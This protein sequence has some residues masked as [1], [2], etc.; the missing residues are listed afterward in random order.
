[1]NSIFVVAVTFI[2]DYISKCMILNHV[3]YGKKITVTSFFNVVH[4][5]NLG[6]SFSLFSNQFAYG[7]YMLAG[8]QFCVV[9]FL[10]HQ[11]FKVCNK[12]VKLAISTIIGGAL[13]NIFD[14]IAYKGVIDFLDFYA[15]CYH[16]P[17][18]NVADTFIVIGVGFY[19]WNFSKSSG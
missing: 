10:I 5:K 9:G 19:F 7:P 11:L 16:W 1:M 6:V 12:N 15:F 17:A 18:F 8:L 4:V 3:P 14:R 2:L 13:G